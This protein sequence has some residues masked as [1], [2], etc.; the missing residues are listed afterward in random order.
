MEPAAPVCP[1]SLS[2]VP[3]VRLIY[4]HECGRCHYLELPD[5]R[6][7]MGPSLVGVGKRQS[8]AYLEES[9][10]DPSRQ[11]ARGYL[12]AMPSFAGLSEAE[13]R[14]LVDYLTTL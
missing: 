10:K 1:P 8:R 5:C 9:L 4:R 14:E 12:N 13:I 11:V 6:G 2:E 3:G 7:T